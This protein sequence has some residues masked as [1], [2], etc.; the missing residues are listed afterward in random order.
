MQTDTPSYADAPSRLGLQ[1]TR[2]LDISLGP[3]FA[4]PQ[5]QRPSHEA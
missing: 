3:H 5:A 4:Q 1:D 2:L